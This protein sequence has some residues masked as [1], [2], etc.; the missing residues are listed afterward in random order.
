MAMAQ[1]PVWEGGGHATATW[2]GTGWAVAQGPNQDLA[3]EFLEF[4]YLGKESQ[5]ERFQQINMFPVM[6]DAMTDPA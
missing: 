4:M 6:F 1:M 2:G 5:I 3:W